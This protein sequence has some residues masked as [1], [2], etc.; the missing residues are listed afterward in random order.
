[1]EVQKILFKKVKLNKTKPDEI[2]KLIKD[3]NIDINIKNKWNETLIYNCC[4]HAVNIPLLDWLYEQGCDPRIVN[5]KNLNSFNAA[6]QW[7]HKKNCCQVLD[8]LFGKGIKIKKYYDEYPDIHNIILC[9]P[10]TIVYEW[11]KTKY[12]LNEQ[13]KDGNTPLHLSVHQKTD[14]NSPL[15]CKWLC[16]NGADPNI[17]NN[18]GQTPLHIACFNR[19][20]T[21]L[22][23][24]LKCGAHY[25]IKD[26]NGKTA[27]EILYES[28][29]DKINRRWPG[30]L[31][32]SLEVM[33]DKQ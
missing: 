16:E 22:K 20:S 15:P 27:Y 30:R 32:E 7:N 23:Q 26:N 17:M 31:D 4:K 6:L 28:V 11:I 33:K 3:N 19:F 18:D 2:E 25:K 13:D 29:D 24:L 10:H 12:N 14:H 9:Y 1:M 21:C 5:I 8:W